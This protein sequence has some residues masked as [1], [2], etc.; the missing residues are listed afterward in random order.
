MYWIDFPAQACSVPAQ[1][2]KESFLRN[3]HIAYLLHAFLSFLL[4]FK[5]FALSG[6][7]AAV[8]F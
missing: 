2:G 3:F 8:A 1:H 5:K 7:V 4:L 6:N